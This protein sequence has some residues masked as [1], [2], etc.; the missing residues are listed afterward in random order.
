[1]AGTGGVGDTCH[2]NH[3]SA[4]ARPGPA[5]GA[6]AGA[7]RP[8]RPQPRSCCL[9]WSL[10]PAWVPEAPGVPA[11]QR[12]GPMGHEWQSAGEGGKGDEV[13]D[14]RCSRLVG[15]PGTLALHGYPFPVLNT[16]ALCCCKTAPWTSYSPLGYDCDMFC[17]KYTLRGI[18]VPL[19]IAIQLDCLY[20]H[21][22]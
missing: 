16:I 22:M 13:N 8:G 18:I 21:G 12:A 2:L 15:M 20:Y 7:G 9:G 19:N 6:A 1:M 5:P 17:A 3:G 14:C 4:C 11:L 10:S